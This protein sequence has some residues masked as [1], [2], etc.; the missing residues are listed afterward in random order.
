MSTLPFVLKDCS[1]GFNMSCLK[2][3]ATCPIW[4]NLPA[5]LQEQCKGNLHLLRYLNGLPSPQI[6]LPEYFT[7]I[8]RSMRSLKNPNLIYPASSDTFIHILFNIDDVRN[9]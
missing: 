2:E 5:P 6:G 4:P 7:T 3:A 9:H 8:N 1:A